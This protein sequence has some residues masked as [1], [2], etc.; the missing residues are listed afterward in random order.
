MIVDDDSR[1]SLARASSHEFGLAHVDRKAFVLDDRG[2]DGDETSARRYE[3]LSA[4][5]SQVVG[6]TR[7]GG[8]APPR[9]SRKSRVQPPGD[10]ICQCGRSRRALRQT[11]LL[12]PFSGGGVEASLRRKRFE[13]ISRRD[14]A[15]QP[16]QT[17][18]HGVR[19]SETPVK[20]ANA[21][22]RG[23][24]KKSPSNP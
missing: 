6:V 11:K 1:H 21:A 20:R 16:C 22:H 18:G 5:E 17:I 3:I 19:I 4:G 7:I 9:E 12:E 24:Q 13:N 2:D 10:E 8:V 15:A 23:C 14:R